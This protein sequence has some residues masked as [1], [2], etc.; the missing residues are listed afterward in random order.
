M[1]ISAISK[2]LNR[3]WQ[4]LYPQYSDDLLTDFIKE[5]EPQNSK[6]RISDREATW[7]QEAVVYSLYVDLFH[8]DFWGLINKLDYLQDLGVSCIWLLP[9]LK[10]PMK[11][12]GFDISD[13]RGIRRE[14]LGERPEVDPLSVFQEFMEK[15]HQRGLTVIFDLAVNHSSNEHPWF[16]SAI[17]DKDSPYRDY[18]IFS[19]TDRKY[20]EAR[21]LLK[22]IC[23]NNWEKQG[24]QY[25]FHRFFEIQ[26]DLN[27]RNPVVLF[28]MC[29][30]LLFWIGKGIDGFR[31]DAVPF[32]WKEEG[33]NCE[34]LPQTHLLLQFMRAVVDY[35]RPGI[36]FLAEACQPPQ[37]I[38]QFF[39]TGNEC[40]AAYH[41]PLMP[42]IYL[43]LAKQKRDPI[44]NVLD[45]AVTPDKPK[46]CQWMLFLRCHDELT[47]EMVTQEERDFLNRHYRREDYWIFRKGEG[48][49]ARLSELFRKDADRIQ[50]AYS[51][52]LTL[53]GSP[54]IFFGD[55]FGMPN[56]KAYFREQIQK[57]GHSDSR[58]LCRSP[59]N[60]KSVREQL[61]NPTSFESIIFRSLKKM[62]AVRNRYK[63]FGRGTL[64]WIDFTNRKNQIVPE[65]LAYTRSDTNH[66]ILIVH[67]LGEQPLEVKSET[68]ELPSETSDLL[69]QAI[70]FDS[71]TGVLSLSA[72]KTH[73]IS[74]S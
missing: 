65:I 48:I 66:R 15:A 43:S 2:Q 7:Y 64:S 38:V 72:S 22:G 67:N 19:D 70:S 61:S 37:D 54:V 33:T 6:W 68:I 32:L 69:Q 58:F 14:L 11:D 71:S 31:L 28:E 5:L 12:A 25:Y 40:H 16:V 18:Y 47:L 52:L 36:L 23:D 9:I 4:E 3:Y 35:V 56:N 10:S 42:Q 49:S 59:I 29:R 53:P 30:I 50:L 39:G 60:W 8:N 73:W 13:F 34:N 55:E 51:I 24:E 1:T 20:Q 63:V 41:F 44:I 21:L 26:P 46:N 45:P 27:Y 57:I 62:L 74:L 17:R